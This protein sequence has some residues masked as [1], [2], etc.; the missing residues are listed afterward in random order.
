MRHTKKSSPDPGPGSRKKA[1][2]SFRLLMN[3]RPG[4]SRITLGFEERGW[5]LGVREPARE[6]R[7]NYGVAKALSDFLDVPLSCVSI[8]RGEGS[9]IKLIE[10][11]G[12]SEEEG[13]R[14]LGKVLEAPPS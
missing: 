1:S 5:I 7:A 14:R 3:V 13:L 10:I 12:M 11:A 9:R 6:G 4:Q 8:V 2:E